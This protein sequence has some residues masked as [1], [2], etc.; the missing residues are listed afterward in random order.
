MNR[1][2]KG[3]FFLFLDPILWIFL[4]LIPGAIAYQ[5]YE[6]ENEKLM[7]ISFMLIV[8]LM[9]VGTFVFT[10]RK[11]KKRLEEKKQLIEEKKKSLTNGS[12]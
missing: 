5:A 9:V 8:T 4:A 7:N 1:I 2:W 10:I 12:N 11:N 6:K 3:L